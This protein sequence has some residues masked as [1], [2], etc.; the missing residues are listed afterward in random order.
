MTHEIDPPR[1]YAAGESLIQTFSITEDGSAR[2]I[3]G[4]AVQWQ[5]LPTQGAD[6]ADAILD[7]SETG[8]DA[9]ITD[10]VNGTVE[11]AI[12]QDVTTDL[13]GER[14]YQRLIVDDNGPGKQIWGGVFPI[15]RP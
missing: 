10:D 3:T 11:V 7:E 6:A 5:L 15:E 8:V 13:G 12:D 14:L 1:T 2:D 4:A 9:T